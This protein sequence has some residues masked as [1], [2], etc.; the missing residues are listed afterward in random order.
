M[1]MNLKNFIIEQ[2][3]EILLVTFSNPKSLNALNFNVLSELD[4]LIENVEMMIQLDLL[5]SQ[6][7]GKL[8]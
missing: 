2:N 4:L 5:F 3:N 8:L 7:K 6:G 1:L